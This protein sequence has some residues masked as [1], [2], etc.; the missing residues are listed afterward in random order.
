MKTYELKNYNHIKDLEADMATELKTLLDMADVTHPEKGT[1]YVED[2]EYESGYFRITICYDNIV[3]FSMY[4]LRKA[5]GAGILTFNKDVNEALTSLF[6]QLTKAEEEKAILNAKEFEELAKQNA[7]EMEKHRIAVEK[8]LAKKAEDEKL[9]KL[10]KKKE[11]AKQKFANLMME[12]KR[13][14]L[15]I[16]SELVVIGWLAKHATNLIAKMP[17]FLEPQFNDIFGTDTPRTVVDSSKRTVNGNPMQWAFSG[18]IS[19]DDITHI[20]PVL[21]NKFKDKKQLNDSQF[22]LNLI[23]NY[24]FKFGKEQNVDEIKATIPD[25]H[26]QEFNVGFNS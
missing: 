18:H 20:P 11:V 25:S 24:G 14:N 8:A 6:A 13:L 12:A 1:G 9:K 3:E 17:D 5:F 15:D 10:L 26:L 2:F 23:Y 19:V 7:I 4:D 22:V 21:K 16:N